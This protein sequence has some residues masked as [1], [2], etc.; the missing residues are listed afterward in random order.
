MP[1]AFNFC[2]RIKSR[3]LLLFFTLLLLAETL[4]TDSLADETTL[5]A[6]TDI[7][8]ADA[9]VSGNKIRVFLIAKDAAT[10]SSEIDGRITALPLVMGETFNNGDLLVKLDSELAE[11]AKDKAEKQLEASRTNLE[12]VKDLRSRN[13]ATL[14]ELANA[15]RDEAIARAELILARRNLRMCTINAPFSGRVV[16]V[17]KNQFELAKAGEPLLEV[18]DDNTLLAHFLLPVSEFPHTA[19]GQEVSITIPL[20]HKN[21]KASISRISA[22]LDAASDTFEVAAD[23]DNRKG[24]LRAGMS[25]WFIP[26]R[27]TSAEAEIEVQN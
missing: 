27:Q 16:T 7:S 10:I 25:G 1:H 6:D 20:L 21:F 19:I 23:I 8:L 11:A 3:S 5:N 26:Q 17:E 4:S 13:D 9:D 22:T 12:A 15:Q 14:V 24:L 2:N 18:I